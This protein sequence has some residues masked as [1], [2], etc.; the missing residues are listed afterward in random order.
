[1]S[2][3]VY[4]LRLTRPAMLAEGPTAGEA[5]AVAEHFRYLQDL[6]ARGVVLLAGRTQTTGPETTGIVIL[7]APGENE[8]SSIMRA[9]PAVARGLMC[10]ELH[11]FRIALHAGPSAAWGLVDSPGGSA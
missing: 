8:A 2:Q 3:F 1:M 6:C 4:I 5:A 9:D 11:P 10:A 7:H